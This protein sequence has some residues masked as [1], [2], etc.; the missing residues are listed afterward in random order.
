MPRF[1]LT[2]GE[3]RLLG[4]ALFDY[5]TKN[6]LQAPGA[7]AQ[8]ANTTAAELQT[9]VQMFL[10]SRKTQLQSL[11]AGLPAQQT[12][13]QNTYNAEIADIDSALAKFV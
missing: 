4:A 3:Q 11:V 12:A 9:V 5:M 1:A 10:N 13:L 7:L 2:A 8:A 6:N